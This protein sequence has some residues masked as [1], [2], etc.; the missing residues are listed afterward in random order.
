MNLHDDFLP[1][2]AQNGNL[3]IYILAHLPKAA[4]GTG[5]EVRAGIFVFPGG[6]CR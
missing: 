5:G 4:R 3:Y 6:L 2:G 1:G